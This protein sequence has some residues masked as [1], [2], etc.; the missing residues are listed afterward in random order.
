[1][2]TFEL[3]P[4]QAICM[5][6]SKSFTPVS[7]FDSP[8]RVPPPIIVPE[9]LSNELKSFTLMIETPEPQ[10]TSSLGK[11]SLVSSMELLYYY[12]REFVLEFYCG[13]STSNEGSL[14]YLVRND[15]PFTR[16]DISSC[17]NTLTPLLANSCSNKSWYLQAPPP[18]ACIVFPT[19]SLY[20]TNSM[21]WSIWFDLKLRKQ[22][23]SPL[24]RST[25]NFNVRMPKISQNRAER[26][27]TYVGLSPL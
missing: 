1:M 5:I 23:L 18:V 24:A 8:R 27:F 22:I 17:F 20:F 25:E 21:N 12:C 26:I 16:E 3:S 4:S 10:L 14:A 11:S 13:L 6:V 9:T 15:I 7:R 19:K 2:S